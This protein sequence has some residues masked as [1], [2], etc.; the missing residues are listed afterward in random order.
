MRYRQRSEREITSCQFCKPRQDRVESRPT[1]QVRRPLAGGIRPELGCGDAGRLRTV[2]S[3]KAVSCI[4]VSKGQPHSAVGWTQVALRPHRES[5]LFMCHLVRLAGMVHGR[6][7][8]S[9]CNPSVRAYGRV[10]NPFDLISF[11]FVSRPA[12]K[13]AALPIKLCRC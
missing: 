9:H 10:P 7:S 4:H 2:S 11:H 12:G 6:I 1:T 5:H 8:F 3:L 13:P